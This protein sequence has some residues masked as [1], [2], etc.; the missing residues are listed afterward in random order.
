MNEF[1]NA[2]LHTRP[3]SWL[4]AFLFVLTGYASS[5]HA[6]VSAI[7]VSQDLTLLFLIYSVFL[8]GGTSAFNSAQDKDEGPINFL[9]NPPPLPKFLGVFGLIWMGIGVAISYFMD[10]VVFICSI[11]SFVLSIFYSYKIPFLTRRGKD[12][13]GVDLLI[14]SLGCGVIAVLMGRAISTPI[15]L[16]TILIATGFTFTVAGS[17]P[18]TQIFQ[19][20][21]KDTYETGKNFSTLLGPQRALRIGAGFFL[22][23]L[24]FLTLSL[25][26]LKNATVPNPAM[27][28]YGLFFLL[29]I[30]AFFYVWQWSR[31]PF[32]NPH[33]R[34]KKLLFMLLVARL[35]WIFAE[36]SVQIA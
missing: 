6:G 14:N 11:I 32:E 36:W 26:F 3:K 29:F 20:S 31:H 19:L 18:A 25:T 9:E 2:L 21:S 22:V 30:L 4:P 7:T 8:W 16:K 23:G 35:C 17:Y 34:F 24:S 27:V 5:P 1:K 33:N 12:I 15:D 10:D 13:G 28:G